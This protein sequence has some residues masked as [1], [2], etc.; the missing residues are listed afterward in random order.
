MR[1]VPFTGV[2]AKLGVPSTDGR[3][4]SL[5]ASIGQLPAPVYSENHRLIGLV[6]SAHKIP[7]DDGTHEG[8]VT[9]M[10]LASQRPC[11]PGH[12]DRRDRG[13]EQVLLRAGGR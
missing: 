3:V 13:G 7:L 11:R 4:L 1:I 6:T 10:E 12:D 5:A 2:I 9:R 8:E